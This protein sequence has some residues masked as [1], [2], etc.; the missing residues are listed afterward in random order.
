MQTEV[1]S[2]FSFVS[3][4]YVTIAFSERYV[5]LLSQTGAGLYTFSPQFLSA[6]NKQIHTT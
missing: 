1:V 6:I 3:F 2:T 4:S 5:W